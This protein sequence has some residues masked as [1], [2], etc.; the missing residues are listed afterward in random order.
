MIA[1]IALLLITTI[2]ISLLGYL[3]MVRLDNFIESGGFVEGPEAMLEPI[4]LIYDPHRDQG[5]LEKS[6]MEHHI[7]FQCITEPHVPENMIPVVVAAFSDS[8]M[9]NLLLC[10]EARH[11][12]PDLFT[13]AV[14]NDALYTHLFKESGIKQVF[15][16]HFP[17]KILLECLLNHHSFT[18][19]SDNQAVYKT[20]EERL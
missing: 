5:T 12:H 11:L 4:V 10:N 19:S 3:M 8:D 18:H 6:L 20:R 1:M 13:V 2:G 14:C 9:D 16:Q 7:R 15:Y 17:E